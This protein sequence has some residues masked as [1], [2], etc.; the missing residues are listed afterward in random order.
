MRYEVYSAGR[1]VAVLLDPRTRIA[2]IDGVPAELRAVCQDDPQ[3]A[4][5]VARAEPEQIPI[6]GAVGRRPER[7]GLQ[8]DRY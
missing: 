3:G 1:I 8:F 6:R 2:D 7:P 5:R 4:L